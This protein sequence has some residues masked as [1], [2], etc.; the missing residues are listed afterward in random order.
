MQIG[1]LGL[2]AVLPGLIMMGCIGGSSSDDDD[3]GGDGL[4]GG[5]FGGGGS[6]SSADNDGDGYT[7]GDEATAGTNPDYDYSHPYTGDYN[8]GLCEAG[9][10]EATGPTGS[11][12]YGTMYQV[13]DV[14]D[15]F[16][17]MDQN[18]EMVDLYSFCGRTIMLVTGAFW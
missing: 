5:G 14:A 18:G 15:N 9:P 17:M 16:T 7:N 10:A 4:A 1:R 12:S 8:V 3:D 6:S 11:S 2:L 13:G